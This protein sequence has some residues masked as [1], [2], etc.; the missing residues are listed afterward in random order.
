[1]R[2]TR[3]TLLKIAKDSAAERIR[4]TRR[5]LCIYLTGSCLS[6][7]PLLG[8]SGDIDLVMIQDGEPLVP[9]EIVRLNEDISL[10]ISHYAQE[11]FQHPRR[12]RVEPWL[13]PILY[14]KP[15]VLHDSN[16]WF[17]YIQASTGAQF[18]Q[19]DNALARARSLADAA[20]QTWLSLGMGQPGDPIRRV[21]AFYKAIENA[22]NA[23]ASLSGV[24]LTERRF[25]LNLPQRAAAIQQADLS[26]GLLHL[27]GGP[28]DLTKV[29][30]SGWQKQW[31][32]SLAAVSGQEGLPARLLPARRAYYTHAAAALWNEHPLAAFWIL[33]RTWTQAGAHLPAD[34]ELRLALLGVLQTVGLDE[35]GFEQRLE[36]L[37]D[38]LDR[39]EETL[40]RW[41]KKNGALSAQS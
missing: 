34:S 21:Y 6:E 28:A 29:D 18:L 17:D 27:A 12:L 4:V 40:D 8:G 22:G 36:E 3:D 2:I 9:R 10:D 11:D 26:T 38:Y 39:V 25:L 7:E 1:M 15:L 37:D 19:P 20:R 24:P 5:V 16:H 31:E 32:A 14:N 30:W 13:G 41:A 35:S 33:I 23:F